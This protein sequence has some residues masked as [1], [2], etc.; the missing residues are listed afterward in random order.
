ML[1]KVEQVRALKDED[2]RLSLGQEVVHP[3]GTP[4]IEAYASASLVANNTC[5]VYSSCSHVCSF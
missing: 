2:F 3:S 4:D 5:E 1:S